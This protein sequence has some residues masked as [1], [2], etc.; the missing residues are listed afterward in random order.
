MSFFALVV[1][2]I[3]RRP[4]RSLLT[5]LGVA[6]GIA[7][8]V[9][10]VSLARGFERSWAAA[11]AATGADL[12]AG[13]SASKRPLPAPFPDAMT[14]D[15]RSL[16]HVADAAGVLTDLLSIEDAPAILVFGWEPGSFLWEHLTLLE[17][18]WPLDGDDQSI[19]L[20]ALATETL[21]KKVGDT[22]EIEGY[23]FRVSG[24]YTSAS[25]AENGSAVMALEQLQAVTDRPDQV[26]FAA[27][28]L[29][30][31]AGP[32]GADAVRELVRAR[33]PGFSAETS[34][35][36]VRRNI[37]IQAAKAMS[38][39]TSL[40][41]LIVGA[42]GITNTVLMNVLERRREIAVL[43]AL[44][45]RR[46]RVMR[47]LVA[48]SALVSAA[49]GLAGLA[50]GVL[51]LRALQSASWFEGRIETDAGP[52]LLAGALA[53]SLVLGV[54]C[55]LYPAWRGTRIPIVEGLGHE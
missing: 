33:F 29:A 17:G 47:L 53:A 4:V 19:A 14:A 23:A 28:R 12:L 5:A 20:G 48:E 50:A 22:V 54:A 11:Y 46:A 43:L 9:T 31:E 15:F 27:L 3:L 30:P 18:R 34:G 35:E 45:W 2:N 41:G 42:I 39:A 6:V 16:P 52:W 40:V 55:G 32:R 38:L 26:N 25:F 36:A 1:R 44:G 24:R 10:L 8:V 7:A 49:G 13:R 51:A 37:A 21:G